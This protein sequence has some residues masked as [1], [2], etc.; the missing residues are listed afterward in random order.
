MSQMNI[1][2]VP[3]SKG[4]LKNLRTKKIEPN[5][6]GSEPIGSVQCQMSFGPGLVP[7]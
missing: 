1:R 3:Q 5:W 6:M 2:V 4:G 7:F